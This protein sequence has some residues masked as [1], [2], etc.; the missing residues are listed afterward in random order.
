MSV[1]TAFGSGLPEG[2][3]AEMV[4]G[5]L[6]RDLYLFG[7][8]A[9]SAGS[10]A[11][12]HR[13]RNGAIRRLG[14]T[15]GNDYNAIAGFGAVAYEG[16]LYAGDRHAGKLYRLV[17]GEDGG[18]ASCA[19]VATAPSNEDVFPCLQR[20][21]RLWLGSYG[22]DQDSHAHL[23]TWDGASI[24]SVIEFADLGGGAEVL[25]MAVHGGLLWATAA[26]KDGSVG[27]TWTVAQ[28]GTTTMVDDGDLPL[29]ITTFGGEVVGC[30]AYKLMSDP[31]PRLYA[32][33]DG[34]WEALTGDLLTNRGGYVGLLAVGDTLYV[35][36]Y[37]DGLSTWDG[38]D[39]VP[40]SA[41]PPRVR[42]MVAHR[43]VLWMA[44][45]QPSAVYAMS[46][47]GTSWRGPYPIRV[48]DAPLVTEDGTPIVTGVPS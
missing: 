19:S 32:W 18:Y 14:L 46:L 36:H 33:R 23:M 10:L 31:G 1:D 9:E 15:G 37:Y 47:D 11:G 28:D 24:A 2:D 13:I 5:V 39:F 44:G 29:A 43:G 27:Q 7:S 16:H 22:R 45:G 30:R 6:G 21:G 41:A 4:L 35:S 48:G 20:W 40:I 34:A 26:T 8:E 25:G 42:S 3:F 12:V 17:L 38:S